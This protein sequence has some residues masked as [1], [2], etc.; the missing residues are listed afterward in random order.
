[1]LI[2]GAS[3]YSYKDWVGPFY[4][5]GTPQGDFFAYYSRFFSAVELNYT[6]YTMPNATS[7][8]KTAEKAPPGFCFTLKAHR[9]M[10]LGRMGDPALY[11]AFYEALA[12]LREREMLGG[13]LLQFPNSFRLE[14]SAV[15][16][17][18]HIREMWPD[19]PLVVE[20]RHAG[21]LAD[22][23][24]WDFLR[25]QQMAFCCVDQPQLPGLL[26]PHVA[27]TAP[28]AYV[29]FHGRNAARWY[30]HTEA[31]ERYDYCYSDEELTEWLPRITHLL[32]EGAE[33]VFIF[34]NNHFGANAIH[35]ALAFRR[36]LEESGVNF[37][38]DSAG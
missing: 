23:R 17:L 27:V 7:L 8:D 29:R 1:M 14:R 30:N 20:F 19:L 35:N 22:E 15:N 6:Y 37:P 10:T 32:S 4:P 34:F 12:P 26:P 5:P 18:A 11:S 25:A 21:W 31:W 9:D 13:V 2:I 28:F 38:Q 24:T 33:K 16:H 36:L 3:G